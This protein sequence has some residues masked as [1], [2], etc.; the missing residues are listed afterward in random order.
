M[1]TTRFPTN[2]RDLEKWIR[3]SRDA[4]EALVPDLVA[5]P[6]PLLLRELRMRPALRTPGVL[7]LLLDAA[8]D[9]MQRFP[10]RAHEITLIVARYAPRMELPEEFRYFARTVQ[11]EALFDHAVALREIGRPD[12]AERTIRRARR[13]FEDLGDRPLAV[14]QTDLIEAPL[15]YDR[16]LHDE[17]LR[18]IRKAAHHFGMLRSYGQFVEARMIESWMLWSR[19]ERAAAADVWAETADAAAQRGNFEIKAWIAAKLGVFELRDGSAGEASGLLRS[20][21]DLFQASGV[22]GETTPVRWQLAEAA[23]GQG[24]LNEAISEMHIVRAELLARG[25]LI[26]AARAAIEVLDLHLLAGR[27]EQAASLAATYVSVF[28]DAGMAI[29]G[30]EA[31]AYLRARADAGSLGRADVML[32]RTFFEDLPHRPNMR[33]RAS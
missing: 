17:A 1:A 10:S 26:D 8:R 23:S 5:L 20:A 24:R 12:K 16:G 11:A 30:M 27:E 13:I 31:L 6:G 28:R 22:T 21:L 32:A 9:S 2:A 14:A 29:N 33:F 25:K 3:D 19:G 15:L 7:R 18:M 4:A